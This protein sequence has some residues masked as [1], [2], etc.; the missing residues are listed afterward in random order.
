[1]KREND[2]FNDSKAKLLKTHFESVFINMEHW[3]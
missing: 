1:M 2:T 3:L